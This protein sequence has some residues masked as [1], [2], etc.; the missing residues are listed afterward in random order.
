MQQ[1]TDSKNRSWM[2]AMTIASVRRVKA[3][4]DIDLL[5]IEEPGSDGTP[6]MTRLFIDECLL[7]DV[8]WALI[9][10][11]AATAGVDQEAFYGALGGEALTAAQKAFTEALVD[12]FQQRRRTDR[13][14]AM[15]KHQMILDEQ[16]ERIKTKVQA[17]TLDGLLAGAPSLN[18]P[19]S[20][21]SI[22]TP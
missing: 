6:L 9:V 17:V 8:L 22:P 14:A 4:C 21:E 5:N 2:I 3:M 15:T 1:F 11:Q 16:I 18:L 20:S 19:G 10:D 13:A 12:F 7:A